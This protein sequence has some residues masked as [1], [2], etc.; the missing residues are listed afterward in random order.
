MS[1][2]GWIG[3]TVCSKGRGGVHGPPISELGNQGSDLS[4]LVA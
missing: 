2:S 3:A 4:L 1:R